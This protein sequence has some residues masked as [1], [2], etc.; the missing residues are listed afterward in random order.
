MQENCWHPFRMTDVAQ[1][2]IE[3]GPLPHAGPDG[4]REDD[5]D[6][7]DP[8]GSVHKRMPILIRDLHEH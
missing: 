3:E 2:L 7:D 6:V 4:Q 8:P 1:D 5:P